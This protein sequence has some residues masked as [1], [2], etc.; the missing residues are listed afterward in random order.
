VGA[1]GITS[2]E[3]KVGLYPHKMVVLYIHTHIL[4]IF[5]VQL[6][7]TVIESSSFKKKF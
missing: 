4:D 5:P 3:E 1:L 6:F 2:S 7:P